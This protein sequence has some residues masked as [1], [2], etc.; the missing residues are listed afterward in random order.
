MAEGGGGGE[1]AR[2]ARH[3]AARRSAGSAGVG[4]HRRREPRRPGRN[5]DIASRVPPAPAHVL[6]DRRS[7]SRRARG[8][9]SARSGPGPEPMRRAHSRRRRSR[10]RP[11]GQAGYRRPRR[12]AERRRACSTGADADAARQIAG[13]ARAAPS[14]RCHRSRRAGEDN[15]D[16][17]RGSAPGSRPRS[18][19]PAPRR[20]KSRRRKRASATAPLAMTPL[21]WSPARLTSNNGKVLA[22]TSRIAAVTAKARGFGEAGRRTAATAARRSAGTAASRAAAD[23]AQAR[24]IWPQSRQARSISVMP[25]L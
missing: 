11:I 12:R 14:R 24:W 8:R 19:P 20:R 25:R 4:R 17:G 7:R 23:P 9:A 22:S 2:P 21:R 1:T 6:P 13:D 18:A 5:R 15:N 3:Q 16:E 10:R